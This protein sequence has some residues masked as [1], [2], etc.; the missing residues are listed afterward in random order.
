MRVQHVSESKKKAAAK[1]SLSYTQRIVAHQRMC[2]SVLASI[3]STQRHFSFRSN[4]LLVLSFPS[5]RFHLHF[6]FATFPPNNICIHLLRRTYITRSF[7]CAIGLRST[8]VHTMECISFFSVAVCHS[9]TFYIIDDGDGEHIAHW[10]TKQVNRELVIIIIC[11]SVVSTELCAEWICT[12]LDVNCEY[13]SLVVLRI[14]WK[15]KPIAD[16]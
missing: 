14:G 7:F 11:R 16:W 4:S 2:N 6:C 15:T 3:R 9:C 13:F 8:K 10:Q 12:R 1:P 5:T